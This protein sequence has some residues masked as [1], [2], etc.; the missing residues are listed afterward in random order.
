MDKS[1]DMRRS[2]PL[3]HWV[4]LGLGILAVV[5]PWWLGIMWLVGAIA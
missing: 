2:L 1:A 5:V 3:V 4:S